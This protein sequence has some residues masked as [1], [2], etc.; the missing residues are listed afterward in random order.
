[1][2]PEDI[3]CC[4]RLSCHRRALPGR[5]LC[6]KHAAYARRCPICGESKA[7]GRNLRLHMTEHR[8]SGVKK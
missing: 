8:F 7:S 6:E 4:C 3:K 2:T 5:H 1:M